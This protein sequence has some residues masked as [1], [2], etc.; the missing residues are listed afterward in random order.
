VFA[1]T[2]VNIV[3]L[4]GAAYV[5]ELLAPLVAGGPSPQSQVTPVIALD[6]IVVEPYVRGHRRVSRSSRRRPKSRA[7]VV[8]APRNQRRRDAGAPGFWY[9][10]PANPGSDRIVAMRIRLSV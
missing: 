8:T 6:A 9:A 2:V 1:L 5:C 10:H 4:P 3:Y 7:S